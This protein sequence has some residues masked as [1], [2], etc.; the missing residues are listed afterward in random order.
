MEEGKINITSNANAKKKWNQTASKLGAR[1][2]KKEP[3]DEDYF[4]NS[5]FSC[6][7]PNTR[8]G[9]DHKHYG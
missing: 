2:K 9:F 5:Y 6:Y 7:M 8:K 3:M 1:K 4:A